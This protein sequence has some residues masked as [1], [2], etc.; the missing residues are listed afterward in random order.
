M[1]LSWTGIVRTVAKPYFD[2]SLEAQTAGF[3]KGKARGAIVHR[4]LLVSAPRRRTGGRIGVGQVVS[5]DSLFEAFGSL[6]QFDMSC[7][8]S[9][10][11]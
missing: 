2:R 5:K 7:Y 9:D 6:R 11:S 4:E 8:V 3:A 1:S 10:A